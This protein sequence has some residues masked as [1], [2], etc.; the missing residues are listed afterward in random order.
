MSVFAIECNSCRILLAGH[1]TYALYL[2]EYYVIMDILTSPSPGISPQACLKVRAQSL[3]L[4]DL[5]AVQHLVFQGL[6]MCGVPVL[7]CIMLLMC[8]LL[9]W[10]MCV[11]LG[12]Y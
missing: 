10:D 1:I 4:Q 8:N 5:L 2:C 12:V 7:V 9:F 11:L 6:T 3:R